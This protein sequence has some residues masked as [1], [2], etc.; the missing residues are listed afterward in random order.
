MRSAGRARSSSAVLRKFASE[1]GILPPPRNGDDDA[2]VE[3]SIGTKA[4]ILELGGAD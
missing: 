3:S 2:D 4:A 1:S